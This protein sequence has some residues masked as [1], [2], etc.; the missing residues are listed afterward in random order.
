MQTF[1]KTLTGETVALEVGPSDTVEKIQK[2]MKD[3]EA[4]IVLKLRGGMQIL[5]ET[6]DIDVETQARKVFA[7]EV[8][9]TNT[10]ESVKAMIQDKEGIP[11]DQQQL[12]FISQLL[13]DGRTLADYN[14]KTESTLHLYLR[15]ENLSTSMYTLLVKTSGRRRRFIPL[16]VEP[17]YTIEHVK[18]KIEDKL[19]YPPDRQR[20]TFNGKELEDGRTLCDYNIQ[21]ILDLHL[22]RPGRILIFVKGFS[23]YIALDVKPTDTIT[24]V[25]AKIWHEDKVRVTAQRLVFSSGKPL[26]NGHTLADYNVEDGNTLHLIFTQ[27]TTTFSY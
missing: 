18:A 1:L 10:I 9:P 27:G 7:L 8:E 13:D 25:K 15:G 22:R 4:G 26:L 11:P 19:G 21:H 17:S 14:I 3:V 16:E 2:K 6:Q 23:K 12:M 5:V 20:L 24:S